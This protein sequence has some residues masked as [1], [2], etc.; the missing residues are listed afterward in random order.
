VAHFSLT[1]RVG[2]VVPPSNPTVE[3]ELAALL[4]ESVAIHATRLPI[5]EADLKTRLASYP[6]HY[7]NCLASFGELDIGAHYIGVTGATYTGGLA[8]DVAL[9]EELSE[10]AGAPVRTA[11]L[12]IVDALRAINCDTIALVSPYPEWLTKLSVAYWESA[13]ICVSQV[14]STGETFRAYELESDEV[15]DCLKRI[16][17]GKHSAVVMSGTGMLTLPAILTAPKNEVAVL[18]SNICGAWW[19]SRQLKSAASP[20]L[21]KAAPHLAALLD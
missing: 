12:A 8:A 6:G 3:P 20:T 19:L 14:V 15:S 16:K 13:G 1:N 10:S 7:A 9:C 21:A 5:F 11:S 4:P 2:L 17:P 18:S